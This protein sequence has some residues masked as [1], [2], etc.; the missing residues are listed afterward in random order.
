MYRQGKLC[1]TARSCKDSGAFY[2]CWTGLL[3]ESC[4]K[5]EAVIREKSQFG[6]GW[7]AEVVLGDK[8]ICFCSRPSLSYPLS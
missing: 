6:S 3:A 5:R 2:G 8:G 1:L 4:L 7:Q